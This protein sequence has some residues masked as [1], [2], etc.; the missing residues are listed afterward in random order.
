MLM[1]QSVNLGQRSEFA[2]TCQV[3][4]IKSLRESVGSH[5]TCYEAPIDDTWF[6][7]NCIPLEACGYIILRCKIL[8]DEF[9]DNMIGFLLKCVCYK[10][11]RDLW[12][13]WY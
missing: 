11:E 9:V 1:V 8:V 10:M 13:L 3:L 5:N 12:H 2:L 7:L 6:V 4:S